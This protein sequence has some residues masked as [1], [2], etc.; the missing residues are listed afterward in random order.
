MAIEVFKS[1]TKITEGMR[2][3]CSSRNHKIIMDEP[4]PLG[5]SDTGMNPVEALLCSLGA[6]QCIVAK[7]FAKAKGIDLQ[8]FWIELEGDLDPDGF[9]GKNKDAKI[10]FQ[11]IRSKI[12][13]K[14]TSSKEDIEK[15]VQFIEATCPVY[16]S[17][18]SAPSMS[19]EIVIEK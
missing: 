15:F 3:E 19:S 5:G 12:H 13:I 14:S 4:K 8:D 16:D 11:S 6:C 7:C 10:G 9:L 17:I 2:I 18:T 1:T